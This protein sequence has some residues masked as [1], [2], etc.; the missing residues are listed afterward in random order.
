MDSVARAVYSLAEEGS[1]EP[2]GCD[3]FCYFGLFVPS[4]ISNVKKVYYWLACQSSA[5]ADIN[6]NLLCGF[7]AS[8]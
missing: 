4:K 8:M 3:T 6:A 1:V 2:D 5:A 7:T